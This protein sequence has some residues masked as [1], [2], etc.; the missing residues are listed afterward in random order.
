MLP[1]LIVSLLV[2][3]LSLYKRKDD[4]IILAGT[5]GL[6]TVGTVSKVATLLKS[7]LSEHPD[8]QLNP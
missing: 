3:P 8:I 5:L 1:K 2:G 4:L 6:K 7:H